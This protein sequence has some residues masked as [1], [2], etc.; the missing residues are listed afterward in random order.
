MDKTATN[1]ARLKAYDEN[2]WDESEHPRA[3]NGRFT[4]G[5]GNESNSSVNES[6]L[7][8]IFPKGT[9][10]IK[11]TM[12]KRGTTRIVAPNDDEIMISYNRS[13]ER[14]D[15]E[16]WGPDDL[17]ANEVVHCDDIHDIN[18]ELI[19]RYDIEVSYS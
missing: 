5:G 12:S 2:P 11:E 15:V 6:E 9:G 1:L 16:F 8:D 17:E 14:Y 19:K 7:A 4:S 13:K 10:K 3:K 18:R